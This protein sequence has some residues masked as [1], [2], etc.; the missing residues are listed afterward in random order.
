MRLRL[1]NDPVVRHRFGSSSPF[2][3]GVEEELFLVDSEDYRI[4]H[5]AEEVVERPR[6]FARGTITGEVCDGMIE[7]K[8]PVSRSARDAAE[9]L[10]ALRRTAVSGVDPSCRLLGAGLHPSA[11][12]GEVRLRRGRHYEH[13]VADTG[14]L[15]RQSAYCGMHVHVGMPDAETAIVAYNGMRKW[16]PLLQALT[17]NSPF[18]HGADSRLDSAR[19]VRLHSLPRT[20]LPRAFDG[21]EDYAASMTR[22]VD[23]FGLDGLGSVWWDVRPH[24][25][26]GTLEIRV[27]DAQASLDH[28][29]GLIAL[30]HCLVYHE[31]I[32]RTPADPPKELLDESCFQATRRGLDARISIGGPTRHVQDIALHA[33][34]LARGY[35]RRLG[36]A[37]S[38]DNVERI[39]DDGN[40]A[41][42]QRAVHA[43]GGMVGLLEHLATETAAPLREAGRAATPVEPWQAP[44]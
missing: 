25:D 35:G 14:G 10:E 26:L 37:E 41:D 27:A 19:T 40:G 24:P 7:L 30:I 16:V 5:R 20:G 8:T 3:V 1:A 29:E 15:L 11:P 12:F 39:L 44:A 43:D 38:L 22:L 18:W 34:E 13:V 31:A 36:C 28:V 17:A 32:T 4:A 23:G 9:C 2:R 6:R 33:L 42:R 21:W